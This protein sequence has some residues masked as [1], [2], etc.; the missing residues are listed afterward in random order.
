MFADEKLSEK[1]M[2]IWLCSE[3]S[4]FCAGF[5]LFFFFEGNNRSTDIDGDGVIACICP[6]VFHY[7]T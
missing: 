7:M 5:C 4:L 6:L 2:N 3:D 1:L